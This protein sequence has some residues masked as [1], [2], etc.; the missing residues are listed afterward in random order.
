MSSNFFKSSAVVQ[1]R[2]VRI[3]NSNDIVAKKLEN[4]AQ[5]VKEDTEGTLEGVFSEGI[6][7][8]EVA[9]LLKDG[10]EVT[11]DLTEGIVTADVGSKADMQITS[12][13]ASDIV[14]KANEEAEEILSAARKEALEIKNEASKAGQEQGYAEGLKKGEAELSHKMQELDRMKKDL[15]DDYRNVVE[16]LEPRLVD[17]ITDVYEHVLGIVLEEHRE[18]LLHLVNTTLFQMEGVKKFLL[19]VSKDDYPYISMQKKG[20]VAGTGITAENV[21]VIE[22]FSMKKGQCIIET[23][24]A[25]FD[26]G[27]KTQMEELRKQLKILSYQQQ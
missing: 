10:E 21:E 23:D 2:E 25:I 3:I 14:Q 22:D 11:S 7:A 27:F 18:I 8:T 26:C 12:K 6:G 5:Y 4:I 24:G 13:M 19:H 17:A 9:V 15:E 20:L 1:E 16:E